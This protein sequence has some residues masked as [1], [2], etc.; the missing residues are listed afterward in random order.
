[1]NKR[2]RLNVPWFLVVLIILFLAV[3]IIANL[4]FFEELLRN[5][6][7][8]PNTIMEEKISLKE[9]ESLR[10]PDFNLSEKQEYRDFKE[11]CSGAEGGSIFYQKSGEICLDCYKPSGDAGKACGS[12]TECIS[13]N[14]DFQEATAETDHT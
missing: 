9:G 5:K 3:F 6:A 2:G 11:K 7:K 14:C 13:A 8:K 4:G 10:N 1:M 12:D